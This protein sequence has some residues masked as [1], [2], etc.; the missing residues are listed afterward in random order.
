MN[1]QTELQ[2]ELLMAGRQFPFP[3]WKVIIE[4]VEADVA[5]DMRYAVMTSFGHSWLQQVAAAMPVPM[6]V[7]TSRNFILVM[8]G[9]ARR[10]DA[11]LQQLEDYHQRI[12]TA[13]RGLPLHPWRAKAGVIVSPDPDTFAR[14]LSDYYDDGE[15]MAPGGVCLDAGYVH[16]ALPDHDLT[17]CG[18]TLAHELC[19]V[20]LRG[21]PLPLW[22]EEAVVQTVENLITHRNPYVLDREM[23][24]R[25]REYWT[26][27]RIQKFWSG[28]SFHLPDEGSELSYHLALFLLNAAMQGGQ[29]MLMKFL[30]K[31]NASDAGFSA[32]HEAVGVGL[33]EILSDFLGRDLA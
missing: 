23:V 18:P 21:V 31:A 7:R 5:P 25:H 11:F 16:F 24:R 15:F 14:Y 33:D 22:T 20:F 13:L 8:P 26:P 10:A 27:E 19:H 9:D 17:L 1:S 4:R 2:R 29:E 12:A 6:V 30:S 3:D 28:A 32:F